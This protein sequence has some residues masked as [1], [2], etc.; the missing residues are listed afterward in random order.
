MLLGSSGAAFPRLTF[1]LLLLTFNL[2]Y[3][4]DFKI[5]DALSGRQTLKLKGLCPVI[6]SGFRYGA[7]KKT[8]QERNSLLTF[9]DYIVV[10]QRLVCSADR[11]EQV[12]V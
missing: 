10:Q 4:I 7:V 2:L 8:L 9:V 11:G 5:Q 1:D 12:E 3:F 6:E